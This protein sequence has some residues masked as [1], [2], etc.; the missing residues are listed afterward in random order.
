M[1]K[2]AKN[3][4]GEGSLR[5][6]KDGTWEYRVCVE[7]R[8]GQMSFYSSDKDGRGARKKYHAWLKSDALTV[9]KVWSV[10]DWAERWLKIKKSKVCYGTYLN[11]ERYT[12]SFIL[13]ALGA[14]KMDFVRPYHVED[15]FASAQ[16]SQLSDSAKN[17]IRVCLN[18]IFNSGV[19]NH[20]CKANP[21]KPLERG[22]AKPPKPPKFYTLDHLERI[23]PFAQTHKWGCYV[24]ALLYSGL[25]TEELCALTWASVTLTGETSFLRV[26]Q[27]IAKEEPPAGAVLPVDK[28]GKTKRPR[29]YR[30]RDLTKSKE[31]RTVAL[32]PSGAAFFKALPRSGDYV[33]PGLD[34]APFLTPPQMAH[35]VTAVLRDLNRTLPPDQQL[36][37]LSPHKLRHT[38]GTQLL[39]GGANIK[40][41][42]DQLGHA[43]ITTTQLYLHVDLDMLNQAAAKLPY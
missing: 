43:R 36:P 13:P 12:N 42:Q 2:K 31:D 9:E 37:I 39:D 18:G 33:F 20:I 11:Y 34:A 17:E 8:K 25:R 35:R 14:L 29:C 23:V 1:P 38:Y 24:L 21:V 4:N 15:L 40:A 22:A 30:L 28:T 41:V 32:S 3:A 16:V 10:K 27:V 26:H 19:N 7:G 6:R 5:Q